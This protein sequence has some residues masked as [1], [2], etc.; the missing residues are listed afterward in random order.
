MYD[1]KA[2]VPKYWCTG[3][4]GTTRPVPG[5]GT[6]VPGYPGYRVLRLV[7]TPLALGVP[8][9]P[10]TGSGTILCLHMHR[11]ICLA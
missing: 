5:Q 9:Y 4:F 1:L 7:P 10:G 6:I 11:A 2:I 8:G 3:T